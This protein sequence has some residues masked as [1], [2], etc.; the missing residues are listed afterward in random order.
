LGADI[1]LV[2][3]SGVGTSMIKNASSVEKVPLHAVLG[4]NGCKSAISLINKLLV[5]NPNK[6]LTAEEALEHEY[7]S[8]F[9]DPDQEIELSHDIVIPFKDDVRLSVEDYRNKLYEIMSTHHNR[10]K[11]SCKT[12]AFTPEL[13]SRISKHYGKPPP[14]MK[15][16]KSCATR[17]EPRINYNARA[18]DHV[19]TVIKSDSKVITKQNLHFPKNLNKTQV[20]DRQHVR[21]NGMKKRFANVKNGY[22]AY[23]NYHQS[24]GIISQSTLMGLKTSGLR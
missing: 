2:C 21:E 22:P 16:P 8:A 12:K 14:S 23:N 4:K 10:H 1:N 24:H 5:F 6:R 20:N 19:V 3:V 7:V 17:S 13:P 18:N 9:H 15:E 11:S